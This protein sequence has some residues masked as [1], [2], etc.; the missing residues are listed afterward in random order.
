MNSANYKLIN[1]L[2]MLT[3]CLLNTNLSFVW[4]LVDGT[5]N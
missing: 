2:K 5:Q 1:S 4:I 3:V